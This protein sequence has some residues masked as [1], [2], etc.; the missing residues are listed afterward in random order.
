[1]DRCTTDNFQSIVAFFAERKVRL[2]AVSKTQANNRILALYHQGQRDFGE[3][4]VDELVLKQAQL[5][6][7]IQWHFVGHLQSKKVKHIAPFVSMIQS[8]DSVKLLQ[9]INDQAEKNNRIISVL[10]QV[11]IASEKNK[12]GFEVNDLRKFFKNKPDKHYKHIRLRGLMGM[13]TLTDD[14]GQIQ[15]EFA[16]LCALFE[17]LKMTPKLKDFDILSMGMSGDYHLALAQGANMVR[18]GSLLFQD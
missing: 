12:Y 4:R 1:M 17:E 3:N 5:P 13:A 15:K 18:L 7:D 10:L 16:K 14:E 8:V 6:E 9:K 2:V 11:K